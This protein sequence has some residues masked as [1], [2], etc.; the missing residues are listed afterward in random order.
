MCVRERGAPATTLTTR[1]DTRY[2]MENFGK[3]GI[4]NLLQGLKD[5]PMRD[6]VT[7]EVA[8][9]PS[10][11]SSPTRLIKRSQNLIGNCRGSPKPT[12]DTRRNTVEGLGFRVGDLGHR[13]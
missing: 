7:G 1:R 2:D 5:H 8:S 13:V 4:K 10:P 6:M 11:F 3:D 9:F 12:Q